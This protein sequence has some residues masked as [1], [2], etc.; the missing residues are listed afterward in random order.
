LVILIKMNFRMNIA[1]LIRRAEAEAT[2]DAK[3]CTPDD[4]MF[5]DKVQAYWNS[6][7]E[8]G[9]QPEP[10]EMMKVAY[11]RTRNNVAVHGVDDKCVDVAGAR[12]AISNDN[13]YERKEFRQAELWFDLRHNAFVKQLVGPANDTYQGIFNNQSKREWYYK[14]SGYQKTNFV[15]QQIMDDLFDSLE[16]QRLKTEFETI[17]Q[18]ETQSFSEYLHVLE[19]KRNT[20]ESLGMPIND[21]DMKTKVLFSLNDMYTNASLTYDA[22]L[23]SLSEVKQ[24]LIRVE[25]QLM[26]RR[27]KLKQIMNRSRHN[28]NRKGQST[29]MGK[30]KFGDHKNEEH[31]N[32]FKKREVKCY[33][34]NQVGHYANKCPTRQSY[35]PN[36][37]KEQNTKAAKPI[38]AIEEHS[39]QGEDLTE[40]HQ[41]S[42]LD[43][44]EELF[45]EDLNPLN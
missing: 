20:L 29:F 38:M 3:C 32:Q 10:I 42:T 27:I 31:Q 28:G 41:E 37:R 11:P 26:K 6:Q 30:R 9:E 14:L 21:G 25:R 16:K 39:L 36:E 7:H 17:A 43:E 34:C 33:K 2:K 23:K 1:D 19:R 24:Y 44:E 4:S 35:H 45:D 40:H 15:V 5:W 22:N 8:E 18:R 12:N 13:T